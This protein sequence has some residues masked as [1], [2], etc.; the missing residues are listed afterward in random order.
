MTSNNKSENPA[1]QP[2]RARKC[3]CGCGAQLD[4]KRGH[5]RYLNAS[6]RMRAW[7]E[8]HRKADK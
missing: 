2:N 8:Q 5:G 4:K 1:M 6:H 7:R 3:G